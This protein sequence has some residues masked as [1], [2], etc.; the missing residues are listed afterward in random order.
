MCTQCGYSVCNCYNTNYSTN[1]YRV[2]TCAPCSTTEVCKKVIPAKCTFYKG[3]NLSDLGLTTDVNVQAVLYAINVV[4][5]EIKA[6]ILL[7]KNSQQ[8][9]NANILAAL[10]DINSRLNVL[11]GGSHPAYTI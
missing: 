9:T 1:W 6:S 3:S 7:N 8:D 5:G 11:E 10:N 4:V 2:D